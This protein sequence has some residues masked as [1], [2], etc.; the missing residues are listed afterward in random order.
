MTIELFGTMASLLILLSLVQRNI[1]WLRILNAS[2]ALCFCF[3]GYLISSWPVMGMNG[4]LLIINLFYLIREK[5][6]NDFF[7]Y[8]EIECRDSPYLKKFL[9][10][11]KKDIMEFIPA[12]PFPPPDDSR[13]FVILRNALPVSVIIFNEVSRGK[14]NILLDYAV[15]RY[16]DRMS[17]RYFFNFVAKKLRPGEFV[18]FYAIGGSKKHRAY[19]KSMW[20]EAEENDQFVRQ[21]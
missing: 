19:L 4:F 5:F 12:A 7:D 8:M 11:H 21:G 1:R 3:Y 6:K 10:F 17:A 20:F 2:G 14:F 9:L 15:P 16:R 13:I 18:E